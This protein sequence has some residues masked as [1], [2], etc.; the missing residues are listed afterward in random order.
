MDF[1]Q[2]LVPNRMRITRAIRLTEKLINQER[3]LVSKL[4]AAHIFARVHQ[5][6]TVGFSG[7]T[8]VRFTG[9][10]EQL[11]KDV[12]HMIELDQWSITKFEEYKAQHIKFHPVY[13]EDKEWLRAV[14]EAEKKMKRSKKSP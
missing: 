5:I 4:K 7:D 8:V 3:Q 1:M 14:E 12:E 2:R 10:L 6:E 13:K 11:I 9:K